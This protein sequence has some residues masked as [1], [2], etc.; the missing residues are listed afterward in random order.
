MLVDALQNGYDLN[1]DV[2]EIDL[3]RSKQVCDASGNPMSFKGAVRLTVQV[4]KGARHRIGLFVM[5]G[6]GD[7]IVLGTSALKKLGWS[8]PPN[9]QPSRGR[10][11]VFG[12]RRRQHKEAKAKEAAVQQFKSKAPKTH[13]VA[14]RLCLKRQRMSRQVVTK[15]S[16]M[17]CCGP[18]A[19]SFRIQKVT[20]LNT[21]SGHL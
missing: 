8:L 2:E 3:D 11:E 13:T 4:G 12:G 17:E 5:A 7:M 19:R 6:G 20:M 9:A 16:K 10:T 14:E 18:L 15:R 1:A 21:K